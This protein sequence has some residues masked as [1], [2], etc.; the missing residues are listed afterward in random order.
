MYDPFIEAELKKLKQ[1][2]Q[3]EKVS[4]DIH[5]SGNL[6]EINQQLDHL[7]GMETVK[8]EVKSLINM[9]KVQ[10]RK[11]EQNIPTI[12]RSLHSVFLGPPGTGKTTVAR[13]MGK[14]YQQLGILAKGHLAETDRSGLVAGYVGQTAIKVDS[15]INEALDGVLFIDEAY[16]LKPEGSSNDFEQ[17]A[18]DT[19]LKEWKTIEIG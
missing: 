8:Q 4:Q 3:A 9:L 17:E 10:K 11:Q 12:S 19:L 15:L 18:I 2:V 16:S 14:I 1:I 6:D 13:L 5:L 7:V